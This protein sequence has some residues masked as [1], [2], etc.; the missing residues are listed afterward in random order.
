MNFTNFSAPINSDGFYALSDVFAAS[1]DGARHYEKNLDEN[2]NCDYEKCKACGGKCCKRCGCFFSPDDF[3][4]LSFEGVKKEIDKGYITIELIDGDLFCVN[5]FVYTPRIRNVGDSVLCGLFDYVPRKSCMLLTEN[6]CKLDYEH[7]PSG[8]K[9]LIPGK[10]GK[11]VDC[12]TKYGTR[13]VLKEWKAHQQ[14]M[15]DL[16][17]Y[18]ERHDVPCCTEV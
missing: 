10:V 3:K 15:L 1:M 14:L 8:G 9:L 18:Y 16:V 6:G 2:K 5:G 12:Y 11:D 17:H 4:D 7:R 13:E